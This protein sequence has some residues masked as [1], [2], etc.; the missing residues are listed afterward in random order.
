M[1]AFNV[2]RQ[3]ARLAFNGPFVMIFAAL[4]HIMPLNLWLEK[5]KVR[6]KLHQV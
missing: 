5:P 6:S 4:L 3:S 1:L 2:E